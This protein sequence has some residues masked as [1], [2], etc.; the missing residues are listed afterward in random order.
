MAFQKRWIEGKTIESVEV[1]TGLDTTRG[2]TFTGIER[3]RFAGGSYLQ[4]HVEIMEAGDAVTAH[5]HKA[6]KPERNL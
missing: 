6:E 2:S 5:Y 3:I 4:F 1:S